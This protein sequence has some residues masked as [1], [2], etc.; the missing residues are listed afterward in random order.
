MRNVR[1]FAVLAGLVV[2]A[3]L[4]MNGASVAFAQ[5]KAA[6]AAAAKGQVEDKATKSRGAGADENI[7]SHSDKNDPKASIPAP[8]N[9]GGEKSRGG[10]CGVK[11]SNWTP[12]KVQLFVDGD[13]IALVGP[14]GDVDVVT[15]SGVTRVYARADFTDGSVNYWG[16]RS[17]NCAAGE[18]YTW[19]LS[20]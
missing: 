13:Y 12:W 2:A 16:P 11:V 1:W 14:Y 19:K 15:G 3:A 9:K 7:K 8:A 20:R 10:I 4:V 6:P 5:A 18:I 17:F